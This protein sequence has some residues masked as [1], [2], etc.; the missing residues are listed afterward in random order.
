MLPRAHAAAF[1]PITLVIGSSTVPTAA[2]GD[3]KVQASR[4]PA[5]SLPGA[6]RIS[7]S[8]RVAG[9]ESASTQS[10]PG[11][12]SRRSGGAGTSVPGAAT[13]TSREAAPIG[14]PS[15]EKTATIARLAARSGS[16]SARSRSM[17]Y[18]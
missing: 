3:L 11:A 1:P 15:M 9:S 7:R 18:G 17:S 12:G 4:S 8:G 13:C 2:C 6:I 16:A 10:A 5:V 14:A